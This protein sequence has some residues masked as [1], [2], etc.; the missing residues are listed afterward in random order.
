MTFQVGEKRARKVA[1][2][3]AKTVKLTKLNNIKK[4]T[5][6]LVKTSS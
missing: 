5:K 6:P 2:R 3:K 1:K 4:T